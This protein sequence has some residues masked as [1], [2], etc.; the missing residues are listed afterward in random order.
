MNWLDI[1]LPLVVLLMGVIGFV[2]G[3]LRELWAVGGLIVA[4]FTAS[5]LYSIGV[6]AFY[7]LGF[8][9]NASELASFLAFYIIVT[10]LVY[11][12]V[13]LIA[14]NE[15]ILPACQDRIVSGVCG[16]IEGLALTQVLLLAA[17][18]YPAWGLDQL[19]ANSQISSIIAGRWPVLLF[20]TAK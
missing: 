19:L 15:M 5:T 10:V 7:R 18:T 14:K 2:R 4:T 3:L 8:G 20:L 17:A 11:A 1:V 9:P 12:P 13:E 6:T 16:L